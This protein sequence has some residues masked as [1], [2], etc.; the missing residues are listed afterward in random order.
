ME[1]LPSKAILKAIGTWW[2]ADFFCYR[3]AES[4]VP[5]YRGEVPSLLKTDLDVLAT[6]PDCCIDV[7]CKANWGLVDLD[8]MDEPL[9]RSFS[10][11]K[12]TK[13]QE[14]LGRAN[15]PGPSSM[16]DVVAFA[17]ENVSASIARDCFFE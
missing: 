5:R 16:V 4:A 9:E 8:V 12:F 2:S 14:A 7:H 1:L 13:V 15:V 11:T 17:L 6:S 3:Y 10:K